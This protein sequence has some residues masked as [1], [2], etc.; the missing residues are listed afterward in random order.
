MKIMD[1]SLLVGI[2]D[3]SRHT[4]SVKKP[5]ETLDFFTADVAKPTTSLSDG[6]LESRSERVKGE[7]HF[8]QS[9]SL[10]DDDHRNS[11][12]SMAMNHPKNTKQSHDLE[13]PDWTLLP[14]AQQDLVDEENSSEEDDPGYT[15]D[16]L[17]VH[18]YLSY[19]TFPGPWSFVNDGI[20]YF[21]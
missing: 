5:G 21:P 16:P 14:V 12:T 15:F 18:A 11:T 8:A 9:H 2:H 1:Y 17:C 4:S 13:Y 20:T 6:E 19:G 3:Q 10:S 7:I